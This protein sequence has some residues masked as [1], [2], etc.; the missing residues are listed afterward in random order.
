MGRLVNEVAMEMLLNKLKQHGDAATE[1][2]LLLAC[3]KVEV[4][5]WLGRHSKTFV[6]NTGQPPVNGKPLYGTRK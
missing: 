3:P 1:I 2:K 4:L 5:G 6:E